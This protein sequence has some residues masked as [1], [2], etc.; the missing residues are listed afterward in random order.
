MT[1]TPGTAYP[2]VRV[3]WG[4]DGVLYYSIKNMHIFSLFAIVM[5]PLSFK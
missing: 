1:C 4:R 3:D 2:H 5:Q